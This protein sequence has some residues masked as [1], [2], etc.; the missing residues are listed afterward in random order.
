MR[1]PETY[2]VLYVDCTSITHKTNTSALEPIIHHNQR[3]QR[4]LLNWKKDRFYS[5]KNAYYNNI[6]VSISISKPSRAYNPFKGKCPA[7]PRTCG[8]PSLCPQWSSDP[9]TQKQHWLARHVWARMQSFAHTKTIANTWASK[10][11]YVFFLFLYLHLNWKI[12]NMQ[13]NGKE[14]SYDTDSETWDII[15]N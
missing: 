5:R 4:N 15:A 9:L 12:R 14:R 8:P 13:K 3:W 7:V 11:L 10:I 2:V 1:T 6:V